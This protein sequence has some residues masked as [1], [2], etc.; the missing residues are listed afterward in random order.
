M[1]G[2]VIIEVCD[3]I[4]SLHHIVKA[5]VSVLISVSQLCSDHESIEIDVGICFGKWFFIHSKLLESRT[6][7]EVLPIDLR[8]TR[9]GSTAEQHD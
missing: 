8:A 4:N 7:F 5:F 6:L 1:I 2:D 3:V 9:L